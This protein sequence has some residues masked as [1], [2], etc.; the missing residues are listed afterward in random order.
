[1]VL[2]GV[3]QSIKIRLVPRLTKFAC[4]A[5]QEGMCVPTTFKIKLMG[6]VTRIA[7][8]YNIINVAF[9]ILN[10]GKKAYSI[11]G[12]YTIAIL[13]TSEH[14]GELSLG[15]A[16]ICAE[17]KDIEVLAI[18][19]NVYNILFLGGDMKFLSTVCGIEQAN[20]KYSC[21]WCKCPAEKKDLI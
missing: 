14:Y 2:T 18:D 12:N 13:K 11:L 5:K 3:Q 15:L 17:A 16:D 20:A 10:E 4:I 21:V 6:D 8:G 1:M 19:G 7:R 9:T